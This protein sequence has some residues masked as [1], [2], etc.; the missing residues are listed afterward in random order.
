[1]K[2]NTLFKIGDISVTFNV[3]EKMTNSVFIHED[4]RTDVVSKVDQNQ[5]GYTCVNVKKL[6]QKIVRIKYDSFFWWKQFSSFMIANILVERRKTSA[7]SIVLEYLH[8]RPQ[9]FRLLFNGTEEEL[10]KDLNLVPNRH[11]RISN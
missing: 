8:Y 10:Q 4:L 1:M 5:T 6:S 7:E 3:Y 9:K 11:I 2:S